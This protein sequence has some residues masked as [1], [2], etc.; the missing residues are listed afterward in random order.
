[1]DK[2]QIIQKPDYISWDDIH[3][4]LW[5][6]HAVNREKGVVMKF[7]SLPGYEI[8]KRIE[9]GNGKMFVA[10]DGEKV[11]GVAGY[12]IKHSNYWFC[13]SDYL[14]LCFAGVLPEYSGKGIYKLL[15]IYREREREKFGLPLLVFDTHE[16]NQRMIDINCHNGFVK[17]GYK[18]CG[19]HNNV[20]L[21]KWG[22]KCPYPMWYIR[23]RY[24]LN[25]YKLRLRSLLKK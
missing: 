1:M 5:S 22:T 19:D 24:L 2:I 4:C 7:P 9:S 14:Y 8:Q 21:A 25:K 16:K 20:V 6:S 3:E 12:Q 13:K 11:A 23:L 18:Y 15:Y 17:V 10:L